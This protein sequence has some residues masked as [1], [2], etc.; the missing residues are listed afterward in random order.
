MPFFMDFIYFCEIIRPNDI[1]EMKTSILS[2]IFYI[3]FVNIGFAQIINIEDRRNSALDTMG[4]SGF[5]DG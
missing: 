4:C 2:F 5:L 3:L 1:I